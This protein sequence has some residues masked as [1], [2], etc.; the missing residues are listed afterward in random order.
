MEVLSKVILEDLRRS[1]RIEVPDA[2]LLEFKEKVIQFGT[3]V[4]LRALPD[5]YIDQANKN[6]AFQGRVVVVKS[7]DKGDT[8]AYSRQNMLYTQAIRGIVN[9][10]VYEKDIVNASI[11]RVLSAQLQWALVLACAV[12]PSIEILISNT[13]EQGLVYKEEK[14]VKGYCPDSFPAKLTVYLYER[15]I[16]F[17][18]STD[19]GLIVIPTE[20][21]EH[22]GDKLKQFVLDLARYNELG[23]DFEQWIEKS[24]VF[25]NSLVDRIVPGRP[26][27]DLYDT[28]TDKLQYKDELLIMSE[29]YHLW[30]IEGGDTVKHKLAFATQDSGIKIVPDITLYKELKLRLLNA[31]HILACGKAIKEGYPTVKL[32]MQQED[33]KDWIKSLMSE[34]SICIPVEIEED[35]IHQ[36]AEAV[37]DRF[38]N[39]Y[40]EHFW[41]DITLNYT[42][43]I[44]AR[45]IPLIYKHIEK[46]QQLPVHCTEGLAYYFYLLFHIRLQQHALMVSM[47]DVPE[48]E[49]RDPKA[50]K[51]LEDFA[52]QSPAI[53]IRH[54]LSK[55]QIWGSNLADIPGFADAIYNQFRSLT[56]GP[57]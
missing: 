47:P 32:A 6:G 12:E 21:V 50:G 2:A 17:Q 9:G 53:A 41:K 4:L 40:I 19:K 52:A 22:N 33:F 26:Q 14:I 8:G 46:H 3:G 27:N 56:D 43:K 45:V 10:K 55:E 48:F 23:L 28:L 42:D 20:L 30:A 7:T 11:S 13:T 39:P 1:G 5:Y 51:I 38:S 24:N 15:F 44:K 31:T 35:I 34:I 37:L 29:P 16:H 49:L 57:H 54:W 25:C 18:A 36:F